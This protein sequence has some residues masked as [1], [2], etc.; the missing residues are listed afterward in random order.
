MSPLQTV[1]S[2]VPSV[3]PDTVLSWKSRCW[4]CHNKND[5]KTDILWLETTSSLAPIVAA[6][7]TDFSAN[8]NADPPS[9]THLLQA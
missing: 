1:V 7:S 9:A 4:K 8:L 3:V 6:G 5:I 2:P